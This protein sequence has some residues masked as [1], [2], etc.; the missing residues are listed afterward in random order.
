MP[1]EYTRDQY[2]TAANNFANRYGYKNIPDHIN[3]V[4]VSIMYTR[5]GVQIGGSFVEAVCNNN[6]H[7]AISRADKTCTEYIRL[8]SLCH[9]FCRVENNG[10]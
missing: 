6:L 8:L 4:M 2:S 10:Q 7:D 5:D 1:K 3:D 9:R